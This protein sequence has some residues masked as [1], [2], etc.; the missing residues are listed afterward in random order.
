ML[1]NSPVRVA[2]ALAAALFVLGATTGEIVQLTVKSPAP[3][4]IRGGTVP[5]EVRVQIAPGWHIHGHE[6]DEPFLIPTELTLDLPPGVRAGAIR[7]PEAQGRTFRFAPTKVLH[8]YEGT[9]RITTS[10]TVPAEYAGAEVPI[11]A[12]LKYQACTDTTCAPP[13]TASA[14]LVLPVAD[15][16]EA[17]VRSSSPGI[18]SGG[19]D[20]SEF[21]A[22]RGRLLTLLL[23]WILGLGLNL[24]PCV[25]PLISVTVAY[26]GRQSQASARHRGLLAAA[27]V[28]GIV[29]S[30]TALGVAAASSGAMFGSWLQQPWVLVGLAG[31]MLVL[32]GSSFG[33]YNLRLPTALTRVAGQ[34][35]PGVLGS[36]AMGASMGIVAAP[37]VGPVL[38]GLLAFVS[39]QGDLWLALQLFAALAL[40]LGSPYLVLAF[41]VSSLKML[42]RSGGWLLWVERAFGFLLLAMA[43]YFLSPLLPRQ[44]VSLAYAAVAIAA[45]LVLGLLHV[46]ARK[47]W[48]RFQHAVG[49]TLALFG[50]WLALPPASRGTIRWEP[51]TEQALERAQQENKPVL[52]DFVADW[53][54][55]CHE[56]EATTFADRRVA[57]LAEG[58][59]MLRADLTLET[60]HTKSITE[61]FEVRGVPTIVLLDANGRE[62]HRMVGYVAPEELALAMEKLIQQASRAA[63]ERSQNSIV[64]PSLSSF[65]RSSKVTRA[66]A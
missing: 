17:G 61:R 34:T 6:A 20:F 14:E 9:V 52:I 15:R 19:F 59:A 22:E 27:Y 23:T 58:F 26:F 37:C 66:R 65:S 25:Y 55:P 35:M 3:S 28:A 43:V 5:L 53:C 12:N 45:A 29:A 51:Y 42:P 18:M 40:G 44:A 4:A 39:Q 41:M 49:L 10:V 33:L 54:I 50:V 63:P 56:M 16:G 30:F 62:V 31:L 8:V 21:L 1:A 32:A 24:T 60:E 36:F 57:K 46:E 2:I 11:T 64:K 48:R 47:G 13:K 38:V 7:Y